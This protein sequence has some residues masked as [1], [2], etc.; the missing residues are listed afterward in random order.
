MAVENVG[1]SDQNVSDSFLLGV[2]EWMS[3]RK[4]EMK[5]ERDPGKT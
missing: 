4:K 2:S 5:R 1:G 3:E